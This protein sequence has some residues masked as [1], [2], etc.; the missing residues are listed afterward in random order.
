M[1]ESAENTDNLRLLVL[2]SYFEIGQMINEHLNVMREKPEDNNYILNIENPRFK[3]GE[4]KLIINDTVRFKDAY[5]LADI[6]NYGCTYEMFGHTNIYSPDEHFHDL[7]RALSAIK[8]V[9]DRI[10]VIMPLLYASRQHRRKARESLDCAMAL[11]EL[12]AL[13]VKNIITFDVHDPN[14]QNAI[15][16]LSFENFYASNVILKTFVK[17]NEVDVNKLMLISPDTGAMDRA[18]YYADILGVDVGM[19]YKRRDV[20][21]M[22]KG[23]YLVEE[24][25]YMGK[26]VKGY[27]VI[28]VDDMI[29][30]GGS[31]LDVAKVLKE[32]GAND[33][34]FV[35][36]FA[37][38]NE[39]TEVFEEGYENNLF[40][41]IYST[42]LSYIPAKVKEFE[43]FREV[44]CSK[45]MAKIIHTLNS[46]TSLSPLL[47]GNKKI[48]DSIQAKIKKSQ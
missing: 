28:V 11:Q 29:A 7:K 45:F 15:P 2:N 40:K 10:T 8:N 1:S 14:V 47:K 4:A 26:S 48:I 37:I 30:S 43:W 46:N 25:K 42:N 12:E 31:M 41:K 35:A 3:N 22:V 44:D 5:I 16:N 39:G 23:K 27:D 36:T 32:Q 19:C 33:I 13:G 21:K 9:A 38:F 34:Y 18:L 6:G 24:H 20:S 17:E